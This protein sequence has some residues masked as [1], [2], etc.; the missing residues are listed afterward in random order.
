MQPA[1]CFHYEADGRRISFMQFKYN[2]FIAELVNVVHSRVSYLR[3]KF[4]Y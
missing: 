1:A 2:R 4:P 3:L